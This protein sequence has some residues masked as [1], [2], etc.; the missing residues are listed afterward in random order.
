MRTSLRRVRRGGGCHAARAV[1]SSRRSCPATPTRAEARGERR[2]QRIPRPGYIASPS[3]AAKPGV[4]DCRGRAGAGAR[5]ATARRDSAA[6]GASLASPPRRRRVIGRSS[7]RTSRFL[8]RNR[9]RRR[10]SDSPSCPATRGTRRA[11]STA[12][13]RRRRAAAF[14]A[15]RDATAPRRGDALARG[16]D[17]RADVFVVDGVSR[18]R[19][20]VRLQVRSSIGSTGI[21]GPRGTENARLE[22]AFSRH[23]PRRACRCRASIGAAARLRNARRTRS[24]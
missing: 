17:V 16:Y 1:G 5:S 23:R 7:R 18:R 19:P 22:A 15:R 13:P 20:R 6:I 2:T 12:R 8:V 14:R 9:R 3:G 10:E 11:R 24:Q 4:A 21:D